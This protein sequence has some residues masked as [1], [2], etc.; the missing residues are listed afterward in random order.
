ME[1]DLLNEE[2]HFVEGKFAV[3]ISL[4]VHECVQ[5]QNMFP[6][7]MTNVRSCVQR[8]VLSECLDMCM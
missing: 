3:E 6:F 7:Q 1:H 2:W 4:C 8:T 5:Q